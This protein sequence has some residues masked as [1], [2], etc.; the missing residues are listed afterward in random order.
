[1]LA[2]GLGALQTIP[3]ENEAP[4]ESNALYAAAI[5]LWRESR[6]D[7][8]IRLMDEALRLRPDFADALCMG[9]YM[10]SECG[11]PD[12]A[13]RFYRRALEIDAS[14]VI[15]HVNIGKLL[16]AAGRFAEALA[17]FETATKLA[18]SDPDAWCS[19]AGT[20]RELGRL[21][22]SVEA[23]SRALE[24]R[25]DF[26]EAAINLGNALLKLDRSEEAFG[27]YLR[28]SEPGPRLA[29][30]LLGQGLALRSLGAFPE[31]MTAFDRAAALG[32]RDAIA[33][34]GCLMLT[35]GDFERGLEGYE[36][37]RLKGTSIAEALGTR[38]PSWKGPGRPG[39]RVLVFNDHGLGDTIQFFR[40]L[41]LMTA[42]GVDATFVCPPRLR[43]L[44]S[45]KTRVRFADSRP[46]GEPFDA[47]IAISSLP[48]ALATRL[49]TIPSAV[50]YLR[51][52][53]QASNDWER[54]LGP[55]DRPRIG[56]VWSGNPN[57]INPRDHIRS[58]GFNSFLSLLDINATFVGLQKDVR[59]ADAM[60]LKD[61]SDL[62]HFGDELRNFSDT[63]ALISN[64]DL[65]ITVDTSV[66]HLAGALG[67][68]VWVLLSFLG[69]WR[70]LCDRED[71][72]WYPTAR[73][74]RQDSTRAWDNV[75]ARVHAAL[76][77][78][79]QS[80]M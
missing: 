10:L 6:H 5:A 34:K 41:P 71:S 28:A 50:P 37:R 8:A 9:G 23:A 72:P 76:H 4:R 7:E 58:I 20:L 12:S 64:L 32:S 46:E 35:L 47:Q 48:C 30:A 31:A 57:P 66:A 77:D 63:A 49:E 56:L 73:L 55:T 62:L 13:M 51:A 75:I 22:E 43:R 78:F 19:C 53:P 29:Q 18:P 11:S 74:F 39:E 54:R 25:G 69:D 59:T 60:M 26:P 79:V 40:Y 68:P 14:L 38:F 70:W 17:C 42:A 3:A 16:F 67:K 24:L 80:R 36:A 65:V 21:E 45:S 2:H 61:R 1:M 27:A 15:G 33:G 52:S 44:L